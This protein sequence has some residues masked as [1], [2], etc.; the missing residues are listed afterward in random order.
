MYNIVEIGFQ[1]TKNL[2]DIKEW[3]E[4]NIGYRSSKIELMDEFWSWT[5][6]GGM[7]KMICFYRERDANMF[8]FMYFATWQNDRL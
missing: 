8:R 2:S 6:Y 5:I 7:K 1:S 4:K 3:L